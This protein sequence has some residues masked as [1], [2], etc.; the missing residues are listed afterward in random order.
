[1]LF[2]F[3]S[4]IQYF[5]VLRRHRVVRQVHVFHGSRHQAG[6]LV[7]LTQGSIGDGS[8]LSQFDTVIVEFVF[9]QRKNT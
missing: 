2:G 4:L 9:I 5:V 1:M 8:A 3:L 6:T 7:V